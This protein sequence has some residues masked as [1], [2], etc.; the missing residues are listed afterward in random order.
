M[1]FGDSRGWDDHLIGVI[2]TRWSLIIA[3]LIGDT[4]PLT[5]CCDGRSYF[6]LS[7]NQ[8]HNYNII[9]MTL[10]ASPSFSGDDTTAIPSWVCGLQNENSEVI[11]ET[12]Y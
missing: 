3:D 12:F 7:I 9:K 10:N 5:E 1:S 4:L 11:R 8:I 2:A 6:S